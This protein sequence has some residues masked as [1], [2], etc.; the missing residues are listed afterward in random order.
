VCGGRLL[1]TLSAYVRRD[2]LE[3]RQSVGER[4]Q[5]SFPS[6]RIAGMDIVG[7]NLGSLLRNMSAA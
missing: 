1:E 3:G 6:D 5:G 7:L 2:R 4:D